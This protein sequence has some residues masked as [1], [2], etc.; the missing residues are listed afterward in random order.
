MSSLL[1][2]LMSCSLS[3][4][5]RT[6]CTSSLDC[7]NNF[8]SGYVCSN[9]GTSAGFCSLA[10][11]NAFPRCGQT[12]PD[13]AYDA[14]N[15]YILIGSLVDYNST[16]DE[17]II[18]AMNMAVENVNA[19][20]V[21]QNASNTSQQPLF[22]IVHCDIHPGE[23]EDRMSVIEEASGYLSNE[24]QTA[25]ILGPAT[26]TDSF[27]AFKTTKE[28]PSLLFSPSA[29]AIGLSTIDNEIVAENADVS[30]DNSLV[31][32][33]NENPGL[34]WR[35]VASDTVQAKVLASQVVRT[36]P[37]GT[38]EHPLEISVLYEEL[39]DYSSSFVSELATLFNSREDTI[40]YRETDFTSESSPLSNSEQ[41]RIYIYDAFIIV[42]VDDVLSAEVVKALWKEELWSE[43]SCEE[44]ES[45]T[46]PPIFVTDAA[47]FK[48]F[49]EG[50]TPLLADERKILYGT[51]PGSPN[52]VNG[53]IFR[54][55]FLTY[56]GESEALTT[57]PPFVTH[58]YDATYMTMLSIY[59]ASLNPETESIDNA[60]SIARGL[61]HLV[62]NPNYSGPPKSIL[63]ENAWKS[64]TDKLKLYNSVDIVGA[65]GNLD[66]DLD[67]EELKT[68][69]DL[70]T[71]ANE[72]I[73]LLEQCQDCDQVLT[74]PS[75]L[76]CSETSLI[77]LEA[78]C[79][80]ISQ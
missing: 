35:T 46:P 74:Y 12:I 40:N 7:Y 17:Y 76:E 75:S 3:N 44:A 57:L 72:N 23:G 61:R 15:D 42:S 55:E 67:T 53:N 71:V 9:E 45:C 19:E 24:L 41:E 13:N 20:I 27:Q 73:L 54:E 56:V 80:S 59:W 4:T 63:Q 22:A 47:A 69:I 32:K 16:V 62:P 78:V 18:P 70:W 14:I 37:N 50:I 38:P 64:L 29:T 43:D 51:Q 52:V 28:R 60:Y 1:F 25:V 26:S 30:G 66:F 31:V 11:P 39:E 58:A 48:P 33:T 5:N 77:D 34:F 36:L 6:D 68:P 79:E 2:L 21:E 65:S 49:A 8:G 10:T